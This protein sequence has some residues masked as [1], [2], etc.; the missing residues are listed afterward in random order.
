VFSSAFPHSDDVATVG[1]REVFL[2]FLQRFALL[3]LVHYR[4]APEHRIRP[5]P[6]NLHRHD[7]RHA[8]LDH[9]ARGGAPEVMEDFTAVPRRTL[10]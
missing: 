1:S 2:C 5:M 8:S 7:L 9:V 3:L 4:V 6:G 10:A